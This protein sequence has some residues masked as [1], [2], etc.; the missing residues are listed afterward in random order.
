[1]VDCKSYN[2]IYSA[3]LPVV[4]YKWKPVCRWKFIICKSQF[5]KTKLCLHIIEKRERVLFSLLKFNGPL[6]AGQLKDIGIVVVALYRPVNHI[7]VI[8]QL[9]VGNHHLRAPQTLLL[10][11]I[12]APLAYC[13]AVE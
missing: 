6:L 4:W 3:R 8:W 12:F 9:A 13:R 1:M 10:L 5:I 7:L 2:T 11:W